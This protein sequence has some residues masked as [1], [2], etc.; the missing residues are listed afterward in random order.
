MNK[1]NFCVVLTVLSLSACQYLFPPTNI[2]D[3]SNV[4]KKNFNIECQNVNGYVTRYLDTII[5]YESLDDQKLNL[6]WYGQFNTCP[7]IQVFENSNLV[8]HVMNKE[9]P[10]RTIQHSYDND[11][12]VLGIVRY[13]N[14]KVRQNIDIVCDNNQ[15]IKKQ[16]TKSGCK[17]IWLTLPIV[18]LNGDEELFC[19]FN[20]PD[21]NRVVK[22][23]TTSDL[24]GT[25]NFEFQQ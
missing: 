14:G 16:T 3:A 11:E 22:V 5:A 20:Y 8:R 9:Q 17:E 19:L 10:Q 15:F 7:N 6:I 24:I 12:S 13:M 21:G 25:I 23:T 4:L 1:E 2:D 18:I